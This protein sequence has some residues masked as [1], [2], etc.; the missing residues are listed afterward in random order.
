M[1]QASVGDAQ[2]LSAVNLHLY[3]DPDLTEFQPRPMK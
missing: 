3:L 1:W 2:I